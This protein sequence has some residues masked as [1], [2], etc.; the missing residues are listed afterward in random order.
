[1]LGAFSA[2][3]GAG[4]VDAVERDGRHAAAG[5]DR[6]RGGGRRHRGPRADGRADRGGRAE[7]SWTCRSRSARTWPRAAVLVGWTRPPSTRRSRERGRPWMPPRPGRPRPRPS[8]PRPTSRSRSPW[9]NL[10]QAEAA[11]ETARDDDVRVDE[12][13]GRPQRGARPGPRRPRRGQRCRRGGRRPP[14]RTSARAEAA[15]V[16]LELARD[17]PHDPR[18]VRRHGGH[19]CRSATG[20]LVSPGQVLIRLA[21]ESAWEFVATELD[22]SGIA[23][24]MVGAE[25]TVTLDGVPGTSIPGTVARIGALRREPAGRHRLRGGRGP[26]RRGAGGRALEH[27]GNHRDQG[28]RMRLRAGVIAPAVLVLVVAAGCAAPALAPSPSPSP[29][30]TPSPLPATPAP[31]APPSPAPTVATAPAEAPPGTVLVDVPAAGLRLPVPEGWEQAGRRCARRPGPARRGRGA[32]SRRRCAP[33]RRCRDGGA[34]RAGLRGVRSG[35]GPGR[36]ADAQHRRARLAAV[37]G[38]PAAG[39][40]RGLRGR[41]PGGCLRGGGDRPGAGGHAARR[42]RAPRVRAAAGCGA[43]RCAPW[44]TWSARRRVRCWCP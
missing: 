23:G 21:D 35:R 17:G 34:G 38:R 36:H 42:G 11:L 9:P 37:G 27:D 39:P 26:D 16:S 10:D 7:P 30:R 32:L 6:G 14:R 2:G 25:A 22:E 28:R 24:V 20:A 15:V 31:T 44:S 5:R 12:A 1:M 3:S 8:R 19:R 40:R 29:T 13:V 41:R 4:T 18:A 33:G 43:P